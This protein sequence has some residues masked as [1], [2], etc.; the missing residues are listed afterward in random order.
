MSALA[1]ERDDVP[2]LDEPWPLPDGWTWATLGEIVR[3]RGEKLKPD[4]SSELPFI[5]MDDV[6]PDSLRATSRGAFRDMKS[7]AN[8]AQP[9]DILYGRLRPYLNKVALAEVTAA[10]SSEFIILRACHGVDVR[11]VQFVLHSKRFVNCATRDTSGDRPRIDFSKIANFEIP[12]PPT[13]EQHRI[14]ACI[15]ELFAEIAEGEAA[16]ERA[17]SGLSLLVILN[18]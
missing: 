16:Q 2:E 8:L 5:G 4:A 9:G 7:A 18:S 1:A 3:V 10:T 17:R 14:V 15:N 12:V 6:P 13:T 11:Y